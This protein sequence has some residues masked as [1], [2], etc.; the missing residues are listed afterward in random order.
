[1]TTTTKQKPPIEAITAA[2]RTFVADQRSNGVAYKEMIRGL[3][4]LKHP[5]RQKAIERI[6]WHREVSAR[7]LVQVIREHYAPTALEVAIEL[8]EDFDY[9]PVEIING[10]APEYSLSAA[11][12][13]EILLNEKLFPETKAEPM[14]TDL[15]NSEMKYGYDQVLEAINKNYTDLS[16]EERKRIVDKVFHRSGD[17]VTDFF[18]P[19]D[20]NVVRWEKGREITQLAAGEMISEI[21]Y[22]E[23]ENRLYWIDVAKG[24]IGGVRPDG[25]EQQI[26]YS[27]LNRPLSLSA[28][29]VAQKLF[30]LQDYARIMEG[31][32][33][34][35]A[36][37]RE[38]FRIDIG[39][40]IKFPPLQYAHQIEAF[41][42]SNGD[43]IYRINF[44]GHQET[45][46]PSDVAGSPISIAIDNKNN[47][48]YW[49][50]QRSNRLKR[51]NVLDGSNVQDICEATIGYAST[52]T[53]VDEST[54]N[55]YFMD[56]TDS[57]QA[58]LCMFDVKKGAKVELKVIGDKFIGSGLAL[59]VK[60]EKDPLAKWA[61]DYHNQVQWWGTFFSPLKI[62][63]EG[64]LSIAGIA[65]PDYA[66]DP[67]TNKLVFQRFDMNKADPYGEITFEV[68]NGINT[69]TGK[70]W[71][72]SGDGPV[73]YNASS[74]A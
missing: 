60:E 58:V 26:I 41:Y 45:V 8:K 28:D 21:R 68:K 14:A 12:M 20:G 11:E 30:W 40:H 27:R 17:K 38:R 5:S 18:F 61:G 35:Q 25:Q 46:I 1:M 67:D 32:T 72:R 54:G 3:K 15:A 42:W 50:D 22:L 49:I 19:L 6:A 59:Q 56:R 65:V 74:R 16:P 51:A 73:A 33:N 57:P 37:P 34:G 63:T 70:I 24:H 29:A 47:W 69:F 64:K 10:V 48:L 62:D 2:A 31:A 4:Q 9:G 23:S 66:F 36:P 55:V 7:I 44:A 71:P 39:G 53:T 52:G 13:C 43:A